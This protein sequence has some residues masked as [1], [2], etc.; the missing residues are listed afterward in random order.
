MVLVSHSHC[1]S[2]SFSSPNSPLLPK[3][4]NL[5]F[6]YHP[7]NLNSTT[8]FFFVFFS[9]II[10]YHFFFL[11]L[12]THVCSFVCSFTRNNNNNTRVDILNQNKCP[13]SLSD[14]R[15]HFSCCSLKPT[16]QSRISRR[17]LVLLGLT[18]VSLTCPFSPGNV[19]LVL[20]CSY[21]IGFLTCGW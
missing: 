8:C 20:F 18:S 2:L 14:E 13:L 1:P 21:D 11:K 12:F 15:P 3:K 9:L 5:I 16:S 7:F 10:F 6:R 19:I 4:Y 17:D